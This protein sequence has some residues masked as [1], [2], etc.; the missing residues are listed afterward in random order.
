MGN[1]SGQGHAAQMPAEAA[2]WNWG[3]FLLTWIWGIGNSTFIAFLCFVPFV[4]LVMPF[5]LGARGGEWA[6]RNKRWE[7]IEHFRAT[8]RKWS[9][10]GLVVL[11]AS[12]VFFTVFFAAMFFA[13]TTAMKHSGAYQ[14]AVRQL[15]ASPDIVRIL[16]HPIST[17]IPN[18]TFSS[19]NGG[20]KALFSFSASGPKGEGKVAIKAFKANGTWHLTRAIFRDADSGRV[21]PFGEHARG[22]PADDNK[23]THSN[24]IFTRTGWDHRGD[25]NATSAHYSP[26]SSFHRSGRS[27][28]NVRMR[29]AHSASSRT[30]SSTPRERSNISSPM[31]LRFSPMTTRGIPYNRMAPLHIAH[32]DKV[33]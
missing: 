19:S 33:V 25:W 24:R 17:G 12:V 31:K 13:V 20:G 14:S 8:Q 28:M 4:N 3:A 26:M 29:S 16:G 7:S 22:A 9:I 10:W 23:P 27:S 18:G 1:T 30:S 6:W 5:V 32:G 2:R 11:I 15:K 21:I